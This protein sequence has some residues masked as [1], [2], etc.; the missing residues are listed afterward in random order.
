LL[1]RVI[2]PAIKSDDALPENPEGEAALAAGI[3]KLADTTPQSV[4]A[5]PAIAA[6]VSGQHYTFTSEDG[7]YSFSLV[8]TFTEGSST[9][10]VQQNDLTPLEIGLDGVL[11]VTPLP[12][13]DPIFARGGWT[14]DNRFGFSLEGPGAGGSPSMW[15]LTFK[16][17]KGSKEKPVSLLM[18]DTLAGEVYAYDG[19][20]TSNP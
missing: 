9:A 11:R 13:S 12:D 4:A 10:L 20:A 19:E 1:E 15:T 16:E 7:S 14:A 6:Q 2:L 8:L 18:R 5:L 17:Q 3:A